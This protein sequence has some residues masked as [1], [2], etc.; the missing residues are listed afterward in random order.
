MNF[1]QLQV[2]WIGKFI[3]LP[4]QKMHNHIHSFFHMIYIIGGKGWLKSQNNKCILEGG[5]LFLV[6]P[7]YEHEYLSDKLNPLKTIEVKFNLFD[8]T[9]LNNITNINQDLNINIT[10]I[11]NILED[12]LN[13][14]LL[15]DYYYIERIKADIYTILLKILRQCRYEKPHSE[16]FSQDFTSDYDY[17]GIDLRKI[18]QYI[19]DNLGSLTTLTSL[20][21]MGGLTPSYL[22]RIF[23]EKYGITPMHYV[24]NLRLKKAKELLMFSELNITQIA[25]RVGF[26]TI[27]Y[28][29]RYF[30]EKENLSPSEYRAKVNNCKF[31]VLNGDYK[32]GGEIPVNE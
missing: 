30:K 31:L 23:K 21:K 26:Q 15:K 17:K 22:C 18:F 24:N 10:E 12:A 20:S 6:P 27:H 7:N 29:S 9:L 25:N 19:E 3:Y 11:K 28:F 16:T 32:L 2:L 13:E 5:Q 14:A 4:G 8:E 1:E